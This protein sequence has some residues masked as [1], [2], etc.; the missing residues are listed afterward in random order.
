MT[1]TS[2]HIAP[3]SAPLPPPTI[4]EL[5]KDVST[6]LSTLIHGE[7]ELAK[8]EVTASVK[9]AGTGVV[10]FLAAAVVA[11]FSLTFGLIALAEG[12]IALGLWRWLG[13]LLV[14]LLLVLIAAVLVFLGIRKVKRVKAPQRTIAT[15]KDTVAFLKHPTTVN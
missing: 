4:G 3:E 7:I 13:Y 11:V 8:S 9:N 10:M 2:A 6:H 1:T 15:T 12:L 5:A 14:F